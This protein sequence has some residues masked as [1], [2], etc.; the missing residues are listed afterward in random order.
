MGAQIKTGILDWPFYE[1]KLGEDSTGGTDEVPYAQLNGKYNILT[2]DS[3]DG[4]CEMRDMNIATDPGKWTPEWRLKTKYPDVFK[5]TIYQISEIQRSDVLCIVPETMALHLRH[6]CEE[7]QLGFMDKN[8][9]LKEV[10]TN[11]RKYRLRDSSIFE[12]RDGGMD[13]ASLRKVEENIE[14]I[15]D[16]DQVTDRNALELDFIYLKMTAVFIFDLDYCG[17]KNVAQKILDYLES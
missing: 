6:I 15:L 8:S 13:T 3:Q 1:G 2:L 5:Q 16:W 14:I 11:K 17:L 4:Y 12:F 10:V 9:P 7:L